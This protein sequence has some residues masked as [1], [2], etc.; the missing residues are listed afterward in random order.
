MNRI[1]LPVLLALLVPLWP[2]AGTA[3]PPDDDTWLED[4]AWFDDDSE[5]R[6][7]AVNEGE[8]AF[9]TT[10]PQRAV[11]HHANELR[12]EPQSLSHGWVGVRQCHDNLDPVPAL[13]I[14]FGDIR[15]IEIVETRDLGRAWVD[16]NSIQV[17]DIRPGARLCLEAQTRALHPLGNGQY[18]L[19]TG[20]YMRRFLDGYYPMR[21]SVDV[22]YP[23]TLTAQLV[24][25]V[26][27]P[28]FTP[29]HRPGAWSIDTL[30]EGRLHLRVRFAPVTLQRAAT[31]APAT[32]Q[33][34]AG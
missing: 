5:Q 13:Q 7:L 12:I 31:P 3:A 8:L 24:T 26:E 6:A 19:R 15:D 28:G 2:L 11:H 23:A 14:V 17:E 4:D 32:L 29:E 18:E 20:P 16:G 22:R 27:Q 33:Q 9:L 34:T 30:F 1:A 25:P 10:P 21:V